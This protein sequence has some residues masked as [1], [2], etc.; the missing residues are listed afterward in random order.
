MALIREPEKETNQNMLKTMSMMDGMS[1]SSTIFW[2]ILSIS[3]SFIS[4]IW[5]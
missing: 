3:L 5:L 1:L 2:R 4:G